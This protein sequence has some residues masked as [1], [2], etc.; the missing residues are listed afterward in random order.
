LKKDQ[1]ER[2]KRVDATLRVNRRSGAE[3]EG[4][5]GGAPLTFAGARAK[6][7]NNNKSGGGS[8]HIGKK[9][10]VPSKRREKD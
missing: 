7:A 8:T 4:D 10:T 2:H 1:K 3:E 5:W 9:A 6:W